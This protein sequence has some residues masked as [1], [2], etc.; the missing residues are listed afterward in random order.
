MIFLGQLPFGS[1]SMLSIPAPTFMAVPG[2]IAAYLEAWGA[3]KFILVKQE[4]MVNNAHATSPK[5]QHWHVDG[6]DG[7]ESSYLKIMSYRNLQASCY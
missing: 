5:P 2:Y 7:V 3:I 6:V 4:S 1:K